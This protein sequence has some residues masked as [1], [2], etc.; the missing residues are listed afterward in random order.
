M[1]TYKKG[2]VTALQQSAEFQSMRSASLF[3]PIARP[4]LS[5]IPEPAM[6]TRFLKAF[7]LYSHELAHRRANHEGGAFQLEPMHFCIHQNVLDWL[8]ECKDLTIDSTSHLIP[9]EQ[10]LT[11]LTSI[12]EEND[13]RPPAEILH[14]LQWP[15]AAGTSLVYQAQLFQMDS[16]I[17]LRGAPAL[18]DETK[19]IIKI[20]ITRLPRPLKLAA[21]EFFAPGC[22][23]DL[24]DNKELFCNFWQWLLSQ[25]AEHDGPRRFYVAPPA[26]DGGRLGALKNPSV[27][28]LPHPTPPNLPSKGIGTGG[29]NQGKGSQTPPT[30]HEPP[31]SDQ[32]DG[33]STMTAAPARSRRDLPLKMLLIRAIPTTPPPAMVG[34]IESMARPPCLS[35]SDSEEE[36]FPSDSADEGL[37]RVSAGDQR[38]VTAAPL[39]A[40]PAAA[41]PLATAAAA[42]PLATAAAAAPLL[43]TAAA[44]APLAKLQRAAAA[45]AYPAL[46]S[47]LT[48][49]VN[50]FPAIWRTDRGSDTAAEGHPK[51]IQLVH[52]AKLP[53][54][55]GARRFMGG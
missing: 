15:S 22:L 18:Q 53:R 30:A 50:S 43:A 51:V 21:T 31:A 9:D 14:R 26:S 39:L 35:A 20:L 17:L 41:A 1:S 11:W 5:S 47:Q 7:Q 42:A 3:T 33:V 44:A 36:E 48:A 49:A 46:V 23:R 8:V 24:E 34:A 38:V 55:P 40:T 4:F 6:A 19:N 27:G 29:G 52:N 13:F 10:L 32:G 45:G 54:R 16:L 37:Q 28:T 12:V 25:A 2:N